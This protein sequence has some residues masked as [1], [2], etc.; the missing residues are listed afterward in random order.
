MVILLFIEWWAVSIS[1]S[2]TADSAQFMTNWQCWCLPLADAIYGGDGDIAIGVAVSSVYHYC[3]SFPLDPTIFA[4]IWSYPFRPS[5][6]GLNFADWLGGPGK[7]G[8]TQQQ[9]PDELNG[10]LINL[11][12]QQC[13]EWGLGKNL[14]LTKGTITMSPMVFNQPYIYICGPTFF[15]RLP[16]YHRSNWLHLSIKQHAIATVVEMPT[17]DWQSD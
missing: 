6:T 17:M 13:H 10:A 2:A 3:S 12:Q 14:R 8:P 11:V 9:G 16:I 1:C 15:H 4:I 7:S 5:A